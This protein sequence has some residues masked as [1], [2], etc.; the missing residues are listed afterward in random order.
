MSHF[1]VAPILLR[2]LTQELVLTALE[3]LK[4]GSSPG[5]DGIPAEIFQALPDVFVPRMFQSISEFLQRGQS[6]TNG[7]LASC[8][9]SP[10]NKDQCR[11]TVC[12]PYACKTSC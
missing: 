3:N 10:K 11:S 2:P 9:P 7:P 6:R 12:D 8:P 4:R 5:V 1:E